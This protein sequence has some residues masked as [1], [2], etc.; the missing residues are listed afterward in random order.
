[1]SIKRSE[2]ISELAKALVKFN[3]K[4]GK[5]SKDAKNPFFKNNY[6]TLDNIIDE[7][8]PILAECGLNILQLPSGDGNNI[9]ISTLLMH[10]SGEWL[11][12]DTLTMKPVKSDP[13]GMGSAI[14]YARRYALQSFLSL[15]TGEDDDGNNASRPTKSKQTTSESPTPITSQEVGTLK[16]KVLELA[17]LRNLKDVDVYQT[18]KVTDV[19]KLTSKEAQECIAN[20]DKWI[21]NAK[22]EIAK[23]Q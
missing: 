16:M 3:A 22:K 15:N 13:Q 21:T 4:V 11:E 17:Q 18:I 6:A 7:V 1:M 5:I 14:T 8:R 19:T 23:K 12:S 2:S 9:Q 10:E 20:L